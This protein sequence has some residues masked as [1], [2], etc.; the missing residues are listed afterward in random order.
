MPPV[1][2]GQKK[3]E[4]SKNAYKALEKSYIRQDTYRCITLSYEQNFER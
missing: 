1:Q 2:T 3:L 4:T